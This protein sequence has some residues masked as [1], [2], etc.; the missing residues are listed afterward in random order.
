MELWEY[1]RKVKIENCEVSQE[2][3]EKFLFPQ[4]MKKVIRIQKINGKDV[5]DYTDKHFANQYLGPSAMAKAD[6]GDAIYI[7]FIS[8]EFSDIK[9]TLRIEEIEEYYCTV[10]DTTMRIRRMGKK[11]ECNLDGLRLSITREPQKRYPK[12][13]IDANIDFLGIFANKVVIE[14]LDYVE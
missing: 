10:I 1:I 6:T 8:E 9:C 11:E 13:F 12:Y 5:L 7:E 4:I 14:S 2:D 3:Y